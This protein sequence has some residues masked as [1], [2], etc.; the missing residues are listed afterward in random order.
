MWNQLCWIDE[1]E[2]GNDSD[3]DNDD[4]NDNV[5][6]ILIQCIAMRIK[7]NE[8]SVTNHPHTMMDTTRP[9]SPLK[10]PSVILCCR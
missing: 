7:E 4:D 10:H 9:K 1:R 5:P 3:S 8:K 6:I 2:D